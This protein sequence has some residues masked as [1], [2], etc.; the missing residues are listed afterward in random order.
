MPL[1][2]VIVPVYNSE[3]CL[4]ACLDSICAQSLKEIEIIVINDG[5]TDGSGRICEI[6][7]CRDERVRVLQQE[8]RGVVA[9]R[10]AG[11]IAAKGKYI[12]FVD[13]DD[14]IEA[15]M[16]SF[17]VR[18][19]KDADLVTSGVF[20]HVSPKQVVC[21]TDSFE[22][23]EYEN[24]SYFDLLAKMLYDKQ[25]GMFQRYTP[26][27]CNKLYR[28]EIVKKVYSMMDSS[29]RHAED[30]VFSYLCL[31]QCKKIVI[32]KK[33]LYHYLYRETSA[34]HK[35]ND[36]MLT[37][38]NSG[39]ILLKREFSKHPMGKILNYQLQK[40]LVK[41]VCYAVNGHMGLDPRCAIPE[42]LID[43]S[44]LRGKRIVLYGAG[45]MG[46]DYKSQMETS[47]CSPVLWVDGD[48]QRYR[49]E[50]W[51]VVEPSRMK[52]MAFDVVLIAVS[53]E[54]IASD[55]ISNLHEMGIKDEI[56]VWQKP[57]PVF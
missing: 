39:Y 45:K 29:I 30:A 31:L 22:E 57:I 36:R 32:T 14:T 52:E 54:Q 12:A 43:L 13:A 53:R 19:I 18:E 48:W 5:A 21:C 8:N 44:G 42:F 7:A 17:L 2:S 23:G 20:K 11:I 34:C 25:G 47:G 38:I 15:D 27:M 33:M 40:W 51:D 4:A 28:S 56:C 24:D 46:R 9:A 37:D 49:E 41:N 16:L 10:G 6:F 55:I 26:W 35:I 1:V 3:D 50:G